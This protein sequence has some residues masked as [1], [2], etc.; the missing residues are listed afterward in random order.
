MKDNY[1]EKW[2]KYTSTLSLT[3]GEHAHIKVI[4]D[5]LNLIPEGHYCGNELR[6]RYEN[7]NLFEADLG[8]Q[9]FE[10]VKKSCPSGFL[11]FP[12]SRVSASGTVANYYND[13]H[14]VALPLIISRDASLPRGGPHLREGSFREDSSIGHVTLDLQAQSRRNFTLTGVIPP[15]TPPG[16]YYLGVAVL[17]RLAEEE[18]NI[19]NNI[20]W[21]PP[22]VVQPTAQQLGSEM[23]KRGPE[24]LRNQKTRKL[25][26]ASLPDLTVVKVEETKGCS[27]KITIKKSWCSFAEFFLWIKSGIVKDC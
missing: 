20:F 8:C 16:R 5:P 14:T 3:K 23:A 6:E 24:V 19:R 26:L 1:G 21:C 25:T 9:D 13:A 15:D 18:A 27:V 17:N 2:F 4:A 10:I 22:I 12:G 11:I 7:D